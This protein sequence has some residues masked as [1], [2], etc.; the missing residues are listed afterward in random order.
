LDAKYID[1]ENLKVKAANI[2]EKLTFGQLPDDAVS[3]EVMN[4]KL[5]L[6]VGD[7]TDGEGNEVSVA[8]KIDLTASS[9]RNE[10]NGYFGY[11]NQGNPMT[12]SNSIETALKGITMSAVSSS[13]ST[14]L[15]LTSTGGV[16]IASQSFSNL[17]ADDLGRNGTTRIYG[18][19]IDT[20]TIKTDSLH[21]GGLLAVYDGSDSNDIGG[22]LGY[23][24][25]YNSESGIGMRMYMNG[26]GSQCVCTNNAARISYT[27]YTGSTL[28]GQTGVV[29]K[30]TSLSLDA[31]QTIQMRFGQN[32]TTAYGITST[33]FYPAT[34]NATLGTNA[35]KW[36]DVYAAGTSFSALVARVDA[37]EQK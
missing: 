24:D 5:Q 1:A 6:V 7:I 19:L 10:V 13:G 29:C 15:T 3:I 27:V 37:L 18:G 36:F 8:A 31:Y 21:L 28:A 22:Y 33:S 11:D 30:S 25:G 4:D 2:T 26:N 17:T 20:G 34:T 14:T 32:L 35:Y 16:E 9:I 23:D 12:V